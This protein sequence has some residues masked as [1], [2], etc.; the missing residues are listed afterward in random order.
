MTHYRYRFGSMRNWLA[1]AGLLIFGAHAGRAAELFRKVL[2]PDGDPRAITV[3]EV[4][5]RPGE[6]HSPHSHD[7][8]TVVYVLQG[9]IESQV[10]GEQARTYQAG[11]TF[12]EA[13]GQKHIV[14]RNKS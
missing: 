8:H 2:P 1:V 5:F 4:D 10:E 9:E 14:S 7:A 12:Y 3:V 6:S 13:P 11:A